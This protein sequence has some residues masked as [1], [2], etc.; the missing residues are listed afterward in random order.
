MRALLLLL[1]LWPLAAQTSSNPAVSGEWVADEA[2]MLSDADHS[3]L[4]ALLQR[5]HRRTDAQV[6]VLTVPRITGMGSRDYATKRFNEWRLG[7]ADKNDGVLVLLARQERFIEIVTGSGL[8]KSLPPAPP[9][10]RPPTRRPCCPDRC[11]DGR[12]TV[13]SACRAR[14]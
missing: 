8:T 12:G 6:V 1:T 4:R 5:I 14:A 13:G 11:V 10:G 2:A 9:W 3:R 7:S